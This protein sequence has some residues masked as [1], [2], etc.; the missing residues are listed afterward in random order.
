M[1]NLKPSETN[2]E[3][4]HETND[5][6]RKINLAA[7]LGYPCLED[8]E[9]ELG[10]DWEKLLV[11]DFNQPTDL[12][13]LAKPKRFTNLNIINDQLQTVLDVYNQHT[14]LDQA[15]NIDSDERMECLTHL[16]AL[17][18]QIQAIVDH[19]VSLTYPINV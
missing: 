6:N 16:K 15:G 8:L 1:N 12:D 19:E 17:S 14:V 5:L 3:F 13:G 7:D 11:Y 2:Q 9:D 10:T 18:Q 4:N